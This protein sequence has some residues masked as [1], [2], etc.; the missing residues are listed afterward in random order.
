MLEIWAAEK[1]LKR[2]CIYKLGSADP[3]SYGEIYDH[4][5]YLNKRVA[6]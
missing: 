2:C 3:K 5:N 4:A 1:V 6:W